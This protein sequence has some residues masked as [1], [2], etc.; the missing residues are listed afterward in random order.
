MITVLEIAFKK[1]ILKYPKQLHEL[2][3]NYPLAPELEI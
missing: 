2:H 3:N 1:S